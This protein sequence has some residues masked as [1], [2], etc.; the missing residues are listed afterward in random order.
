MMYRNACSSRIAVSGFVLF[1]LVALVP[2]LPAGVAAAPAAQAGSTPIFIN[3]IHY[4]NFGTDAGE[5]VEIAGPSGTDLSGWSNVLYNGS[6]GLSYS[7]TALTGVIPD[8]DDGFGTVYVS[9][10]VNGIQ[11]GA[12]DGLALVDGS[13]IVQFLSYEGSFVAVDG[14]A[15]GM[16]STDVGVAEGYSTGAGGSLQLAGLGTVYEDFAWVGPSSSSFGTV[17]SGQSFNSGIPPSSLLPAHV[18]IPDIQFTTDSGGASPYLGEFVATRG[19]VT[20]SF[21]AGGNRYT[22][23]QDGSGPWSGLLLYRLNEFV[24]VGDEVEVEG[25]V[26]EFS[27][28]TEIAN[29]DVTVLGAGRPLPAAE[30][31]GTGD[32]PQEDWESVLVRVENV[33]VTNPDLG[34][35]EWLI[36]DGS[37]A[38]RVDDLGG[39]SYRPADGDLLDFVQGPL[40]FRFG[41]FKV[42]PRGDVDVGVAPPFVSI[43]EIQGAGFASPFVGRTVRTRGLVFLDLDQQGARGFYI[44]D[45]DCDTTEDTSD[46]I[47]IYKGDRSDVVSTGDLIEV[48]GEVQEYYDLTEISASPSD[49]VILS[50]G[51]PLPTAVDLR[52]KFDNDESKAYL[53]SLEGM[54]VRL[55]GA[56]VVG[57]T[58][59]YDET[60]VVRSDLGLERVFQDYPAG[61]GVIVGVDDAGLF[62]ITPEAKVGDSVLGLSGA[63]D[64]SFGTYKMRLG[65]PPFVEPAPDPPKLGDVDQDG[66]ID[67][68]DRVLLKDYFG[69]MVPPAPE[70]ADLNDDG[71]VSGRDFVIFVRLWTTLRMKAWQF[72]VATFNLE[73]LFD[74]LDDPDTSDPVPSIVDY[75]L[76]LDKLAE[77]LHDEL[78]E[79]TIVGVQ[80]AENVSVLTDLVARSEIE[81]KYGAILVD[82]PD[83]RG[84]DVG[85][86]YQKDRVLVNSYETRQACTSLIDGLGPDGNG[87]VY[88]PLNVV[89]CDTNGDGLPDGNRLFSRPP[90]VV[91][92]VLLPASGYQGL[93]MREDLWVIVNHWKSRNQDTHEVQY[94]LARRV[95]QAHFVADLAGEIMARDPLAHVI[96][97]GD[98]NDSLTSEPLAV[99]TAAGFQDLLLEVERSSR[100]TYVYRGESEVLDHI[101]V[102]PGMAGDPVSVE[103][104]HI[105]SDYPALFSG[106]SDTARRS[107]DH[108]PVVAT[109]HLHRSL[110][111]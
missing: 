56:V 109:F 63:L 35:G 45:P 29:G 67:L 110:S 7:L 13:T 106:F 31:L 82:G 53:E 73:N 51:N 37:G 43:C 108:D 76:R 90:L 49:V 77:A 99:L 86:L 50:Q 2:M 92:L 21:Y 66:D 83:A 6:N 69:Q 25:T 87:D 68:A 95:E 40:L 46:G 89:T 4:D 78:G 74:T 18:S 60:W 5:A 61:T 20:A 47:F 71:R 94:T 30:V 38:I 84:I 93:G 3:E 91:H 111:W 98:L 62:E 12:P 107:S 19:I 54:Y 59:R 15:T 17:N 23:I 100:Y 96:V 80:E 39:Y 97:L 52:P 104:V 65:T 105:N 72:S 24:S 57:P 11:D 41:E 16:T 75:E 42:A 8:Q 28:V 27:G 81:G 26:S 32:V 103:P 79:P 10:A 64:Y 34:Y 101:L 88:N 1:L 44:Q 33:T 14:P 70:S 58:N 48:R 102:S 85:L 55:N 36:D 9:Y 22:F